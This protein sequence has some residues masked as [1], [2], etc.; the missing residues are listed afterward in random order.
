MMQAGFGATSDDLSAMVGMDAADWVRNQFTLSASLI[1][2]QVLREADPDRQSY[3]SAH[4]EAMFEAP[5]VLRQR[6]V[7]A[8]SQIL[9][10][11]DQ[12]MN[13]EPERLSYY[14]DILNRNAFGN[15][16]DLLTEITYSP[17]MA[18]YLTYYRNRK[19][20]PDTGRMPDENY[21]RELLQLFTIGLVELNM[22][23]TPV[24]NGSGPVEVFDNDDIQGLARV[25]T[26]LSY[27]GERF[28]ANSSQRIP[29]HEYAP[30]QMFAD[31]HSELEKTFLSTTIPAGT[32]GDE[33]IELALDEIF[34]HP[35]LAPFIARQLIQR[36]TAS[37]PTPG[38]VERVAMAFETGQFESIGGAR[39]GSGNRGDLRPV[40][41]AI[42]L[43]E[44]LHDPSF[45]NN[46]MG[47]K[48]REPVLKFAHWV[49]AFDASVIDARE[50]SE[51]RDTTGA[52]DRLAQHPFRSPSVFNFYRPGFVAPGS[53]SGGAGLT[54][55]ELQIINEGSIIG[56][57]NFMT[58]FIFGRARLRNGGGPSFVPDYSDELALADD[59]VGLID[60][61]DMLLTGA[62]MSDEEKDAVETVLTAL[63]LSEDEEDRAEDL[64]ARVETAILMITNLPSYAI[65]Q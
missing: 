62:R 42:L 30:L 53:E 5:D 8:L 1:L 59:P 21:A 4:Y 3:S 61:L 23:G 47:G 55:P 48:I 36:F 16:R 50:T 35:N 44:T 25:F 60:H 13:N 39:F 49:R 65:V 2:P 9:V 33:S 40:L 27:Q 12:P 52:T 64:M 45:A 46:P 58:E 20:D 7:F 14:I 56:Y 29:N 19:G 51:L 28:F 31:Q 37:N 15:Y 34:N 6:M 10:V 54:A 41:A 17:A 18:H 57:N 11:S 38:Y 22:D 43:D 24:D 26:G 63:S 32:P